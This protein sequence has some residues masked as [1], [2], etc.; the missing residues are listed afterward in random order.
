LADDAL[1]SRQGI[2][3][4]LFTGD[5]RDLHL[6]YLASRSSVVLRNPV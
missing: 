2:A 5:L 3:D 1:E 6:L 4:L